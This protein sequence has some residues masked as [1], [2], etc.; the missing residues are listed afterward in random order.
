V[1]K[2]KNDVRQFFYG[3]T[4]YRFW[5]T[6]IIGDHCEFIGRLGLTCGD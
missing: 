6:K 5:S 3:N 1:T 2:A 4:I